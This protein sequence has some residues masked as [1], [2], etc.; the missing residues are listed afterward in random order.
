MLSGIR[1]SWGLNYGQS[2][3]L[4]RADQ[5]GEERILRRGADR[6]L[7]SAV[8]PLQLALLAL[9]ARDLIPGR[10]PGTLSNSIGVNG[11]DSL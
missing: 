9:L 3:H 10:T 7:R 1:S 4:H 2:R 6:D 11:H 8:T 5:I